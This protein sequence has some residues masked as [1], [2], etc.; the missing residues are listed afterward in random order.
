MGRYYSGDI[1]GKFLFGLQDSDA[2]LRFGGTQLVPDMI[3]IHFDNEE[4]PGVKKEL[5]VLKRD[6][7]ARSEIYLRSERNYVKEAIE[8]LD[9][10]EEITDDMAITNHDVLDR[11]NKGKR[12]H[13][14]MTQVA[15]FMLGIQIRNHLQK[16]DDFGCAFECEL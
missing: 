8:E 1:E 9:A 15:D 7:I 2:A 14:L 10:C 12:D 4:L 3:T 16:D 11:L 6:I 13:I 5:E